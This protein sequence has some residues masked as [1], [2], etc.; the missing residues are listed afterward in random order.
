MY[1]LPILTH[2]CGTVNSFSR[3]I[4]TQVQFMLNKN[5]NTQFEFGSFSF[6]LILIFNVNKL[7][8]CKLL[9]NHV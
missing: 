2:I 1:T 8:S 7:H 3:T 6:A 4:Y 5:C 9:S